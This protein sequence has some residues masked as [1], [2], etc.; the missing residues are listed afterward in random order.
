M[1]Q[2]TPEVALQRDYYA[3]TAAAY[4]G[5]HVASDDEHFLALAWLVGLIQHHGYR[6]VLDIGSGTGRALHYLKA[7]LPHLTV[8][9]IEPSA[10]LR[11]AGHAAGLSAAELVEGDATR[12]AWPDNSFDV[13]C[14]FGVLHHVREP[15]RVIGEM[16]RVSRSGLFISDDNHFACGS[17][18]NRFTK[19]CLRS[20]GL[21][22]AAYWARTG[23]KG[24]RISEGDGLS[25]AY[26]V[27]DDLPFIR[28][29]SES[30][31]LASTRG[32]QA[33][34]YA[35]APHVALFARKELVRV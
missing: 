14:E 35:S 30:L 4:E 5:L 22:N 24:Y 33:D 2:T 19:R 20:V 25:Y 7:K 34:L 26:S 15:R 16:L 3:R 27:F 12:L 8:L 23:G 28:E 1:T 29:R 9:G 21:W 6:S 13:V 11:S 10:E 31:Q 32:D 17:P 18:A